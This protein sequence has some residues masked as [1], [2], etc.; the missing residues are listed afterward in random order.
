MKEHD[1]LLDEIQV[2][3]DYATELV[4]EATGNDK[5]EV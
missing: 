2:A 4:R 1:E 3:R 5:L